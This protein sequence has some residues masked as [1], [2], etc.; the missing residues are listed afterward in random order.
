MVIQ[1][2]L[3]IIHEKNIYIGNISDK[4]IFCTEI[5]IS[6][7]D[8]TEIDYIINEFK[9]NNID[10]F[11]DKLKRIDKNSKYI[12]KYLNSNIIVAI[13]TEKYS[14]KE[15]I[16][17]QVKIAPVYQGQNSY[18]K[19]DLK[20][21]EALMDEAFSWNNQQGFQLNQNLNIST[22]RKNDLSL[23]KKFS[24]T[25]QQKSVS[26]INLPNFSLDNENNFESLNI[27]KNKYKEELE[28]NKK[29]EEEN[30][31]LKEKL[32]NIEQSH[33]E[34]INKSKDELNKIKSENEKLKNDLIKINKFISNFQNNQII[35]K[36]NDENKVLLDEILNLKNKLNIKENEINDLKEKF[37]NLNI[38]EPKFKMSDIIVLNFLSSDQKIRCGIKCLATDTFAEV[39]EKL[40]KIYDDFRN[41]NNL[42]TAHALPVLKFKTIRENNIK[43]GDVIQLIKME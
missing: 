1:D 25:I 15:D 33:I 37:K 18:D 39:E 41:T 17:Q 26:K 36:N 19:N 42:C 34:E 14:I 5:I 27:L 23:N 11:I 38:E 13:L 10:N 3:F 24:G 43:D 32:N 28:K 4:D 22:A 31:R 30:R 6:C 7:S 9:T 2:K 40:Y 21:T 20:S 8:K 12:G 35:N 29:L 16:I